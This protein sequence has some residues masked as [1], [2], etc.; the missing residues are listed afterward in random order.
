VEHILVSTK[1]F[2]PQLRSGLVR[3]PHLLEKLEQ[4]ASSALT[5]I[6][7]PAGYGKTTL[8][9][10][11][12][13]ALQKTGAGAPW[14]V[15]WLSLDAGDNDPTRFL[16]YLTAALE[17]A[18]PRATADT[19]ALL[20]SSGTFPDT[21]PLSMLINSLQE[22]DRQVLLV[23]DD[24]QFIQNPSIHQGLSYLLER[25]PE[26][27]HIVI[28]TRSDPPIPLARLRAR[29][30]LAEIRAH[31]LRFSAQE[32][33]EFLTRSFNL[34]LSPA[35][36]D[37]LEQ[38]TEGWIAGL[39]LAA[40]SMQGC[41]DLA[42]FIEAFSGSH[43]FI[44]DYLAE[45]AL[46]RQPVE[47]Q[48]FLLQTSILDRLNEDL[49]RAVLTGEWTDPLTPA[50]PEAGLLNRIGQG[51]L[52]AL[53][54]SNLFLVPL[55]DERV[56]YRY[57][58]LFADLLRTR[59]RHSASQLIPVLHAR[60]A[61]WFEQNGY[62]E[63]AIQHFLAA[64]TWEHAARLVARA[65]P[66]TIEAGKM[67]TV[68]KWIDA[69][70]QE[71]IF[72]HPRLSELVAEVFSQG[73]RIDSIDAYLDHAEAALFRL[74]GAGTPP[75][76]VQD[77]EP[78]E[79]T[80]IRAMIGS[81]RGLK[82]VCSGDPQA[83]LAFTTETLKTVPGMEAKEQALLYWVEGWAHRSLGR[84]EQ[85]IDLFTRAFALE[86]AAGL[87]LRDVRTDLAVTYR[88]VGKLRQA[89]DLFTGATQGSGGRSV[90]DQAHQARGEAFLSL[91]Y[92]EQNRLDLAWTHARR[93]LDFSLW[94]PSH[95]VIAIAHAC[96]AQV[97]LARG[98]LDGALAA[99]R[100]ADLER[101]DRLMTPFVHS[102]VD[103]TL[104]QV[105]LARG[106][107][108]RLEAWSGSR[109]AEFEA[110]FETGAWMDEYQETRFI[111]LARVWMSKSRGQAPVLERCLQLLARLEE[112]AR[113]AGRINALVE[114]LILK[115]SIRF[116]QGKTRLALQGLDGC[117][118]LAEPGGYR[119][120]FLKTGEPARLLLTAYLAEPDPA[121]RLYAREIL[122]A[123]GAPPVTD[124]PVGLPQP[125]SPRELDVL[126]LL[127][128]GCSNRQIAERL[129]LTEGTVKFHVHHILRK[130][131][132]GSR[133]QALAR[134]KELGLL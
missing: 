82:A 131:N 122:Q 102:L 68:L 56:W 19:R 128:E 119:R 76:A 67:A 95:N 66:D 79:L 134:A 12:I 70:P 59:L 84:L 13:A 4:G 34:P 69:L 96:L 33:A 123:F 114:I 74:D 88:S 115:E 130:L 36:I 97:S 28:A 99:A 124:S 116:M 9:A 107:W 63:E 8:L 103:V 133:T 58:H 86:Q 32:A 29:N 51:R 10:S 64:Q 87:N 3:R 120:A 27:V 52:A 5:L 127:G 117:L 2:V 80:V 61:A 121:H 26:N 62:I 48:E 57:H 14:A 38:R 118:A 125:L 47:I 109:W 17:K 44:M 40:I 78:G 41:P 93:A 73:G 53:E 54:R 24:Y 15:G 20:S 45:E 49:C 111:M 75:A 101:K 22:L 6:S 50:K 39:Q 1:L 100:Q 23:L 65:I 110:K 129:F 71:V 105:W 83:A 16:A 94:W 91:L 60:A 108:D 55:D 7:A 106:E 25:L 72:D 90:Q 77:L 11:W 43:R 98:D 132:A 42:R 89:I 81:L 113:A 104:A 126:R 31:D 18:H 35:Q 85:A 46:N 112:N 92:L 37:L 30:Q 21:A